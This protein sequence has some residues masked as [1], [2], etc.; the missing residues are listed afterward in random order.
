M[1]IY[2]MELLTSVVIFYI[3]KSSDRTTHHT[4]AYVFLVTSGL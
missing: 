4:V 1:V 3:S 2:G